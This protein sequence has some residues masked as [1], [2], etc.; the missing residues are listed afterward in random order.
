[1]LKK[2][3]L[4]SILSVTVLANAVALSANASDDYDYREGC[5]PGYWKQYH[6]ADSWTGYYP[7]DYFNQVFG[8]GGN[9]Y[10]TLIDAL[11]QGGGKK[12][13]LRRHAVAALLNA[14][15]PY[16]AYKYS[17]DEV[18]SKVQYAL[19]GNKKLIEKT[20][21]ELEDAN[22]QGCPLN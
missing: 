15:H 11:K 16:V 17:V 19:Y 3:K 2:L 9:S 7:T 14:S 5:T 4:A 18:I 10:L 8:I 6:H 1:M 20:K 21:D 22:E 13:A 12:I